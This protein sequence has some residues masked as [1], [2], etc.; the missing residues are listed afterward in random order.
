MTCLSAAT[1][2]TV[3]LFTDF[4]DWVFLLDVWENPGL[5]DSSTTVIVKRIILILN[6]VQIVFSLALFLDLL[7]LAI[8]VT[9]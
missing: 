7:S 6:D 2:L 5:P 1:D 3:C 4:S 9:L 8:S